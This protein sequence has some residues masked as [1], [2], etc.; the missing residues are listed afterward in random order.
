MAGSVGTLSAIITANASKFFATVDQAE[1]KLKG[2]GQTVDRIG[3]FATSA[4]ASVGIGL[5]LGGLTSA[6]KQ[7]IDDTGRLVDASSKLDIG[8][9]QLEQMELA[10][11]T[12]GVAAETLHGAIGK[13]QQ[14]IG[15]AA[16]GEE[17]AVK[18]FDALG[19][20]WRELAMASPDES[21]AL[22]AKQIGGM[23]TAFERADAATALFGKSGRELIPLL[24]SFTE[25][26]DLAGKSLTKLTD[27]DAQKLDEMG[28][29]FT[30]MEASAKS[31]FREIV[32]GVA[33]GGGL[34][35]LSM[36]ARTFSTPIGVAL[37]FLESRAGKPKTPAEDSLEK[38]LEKAE[39][40]AAA[41]HQRRLKM[42]REGIPQSVAFELVPPDWENKAA[43]LRADL[44]RVK[45]AKADALEMG[46]ILKQME[47]FDAH[48]KKWADNAK[49]DA[50]TPFEAMTEG[51]ENAKHALARGFLDQSAFDKV[52]SKI[53]GAAETTQKLKEEA[54][55]LN[56]EM[57]SP[58][59][60]M[61]AAFGRIEMLRGEGFLSPE[62]EAQLRGKMLKEQE[63]RLGL[64]LARPDFAAREK[65]SVEAGSAVNRFLN[66]SAQ[67]VGPE[68]RAQEVREALLAETKRLREEFGALAEAWGVADV[69]Q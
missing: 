54:L 3:S 38:Q 12:S 41:D 52:L 39:K 27:E 19:F 11:K 66:Q 34:S 14:K 43:A 56:E 46:G 33:K 49:Q 68:Q 62:L 20:S 67:R 63:Q 23:G 53:T 21:F 65:G 7:T 24:R 17:Q 15:E 57:L 6:I 42:Q 18:D 47:E 30:R 4:L 31:A 58:M 59:Q 60:K 26:M 5:S 37:A 64:A 61:E 22:V 40:F 69:G 55:K 1:A 51:I 44:A 28:D 32:T 25:E 45:E 50:R 29:K 8:V 10:A 48:W 36:M 2:F 13:L 16:R 9:G 35:E